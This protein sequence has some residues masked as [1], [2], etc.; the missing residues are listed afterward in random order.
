MKW[1]RVALL[2]PIIVVLGALLHPPIA[3]AT[4]P[5]PGE[6]CVEL[7]FH[8]SYQVGDENFTHHGVDL[9]GLAGDQVA[10]PVAG[11]VSFVGSVPAS[12]TGDGATMLALSLLLDDGRVLSL[13]PLASAWVQEG[14]VVS[15]GE[16]LGTL[17]GS[18]DRSCAKVHLHVGLRAEGR[19]LDPLPLLTGAAASG[20]EMEGGLSEEESIAVMPEPMKGA[21]EGASA[22]RFSSGDP[23][24]ESPSLE[25]GTIS[26]GGVD[27]LPV[28]APASVITSQRSRL[29]Q[30]AA[31][32]LREAGIVLR[33]STIVPRRAT[34]MLLL[35]LAPVCAGAVVAA[36]RTRKR[37]TASMPSAR[38][39]VLGEV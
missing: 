6:P 31:E 20:G 37:S 3:L 5:L 29:L 24:P 18:G 2:L 30:D 17:A 13:M 10:A 16:P 15:V 23:L 38:K 14:D 11:T 21:G 19:Y 7:G 32:A 22:E 36:V 8:A 9:L 26:S 4:S 35:V 25:F 33:G 39:E 1:R 34:P 12:E 27:T 28:G